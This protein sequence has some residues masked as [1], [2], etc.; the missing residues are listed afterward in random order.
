MDQKMRV[1]GWVAG[2]IAGLFYSD[3]AGMASGAV[4]KKD[5][6]D[7][8]ERNYEMDISA[9]GPRLPGSNYT[10]QVP[11]QMKRSLSWDKDWNI[12]YLTSQGSWIIFQ[13]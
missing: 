11:L 10:G 8:T 7:T 3:T 4:E 6:T 5:A 13:L 12:P 2:F 1:G 9:H